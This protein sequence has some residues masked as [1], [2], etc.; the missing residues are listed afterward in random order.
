[1][2]PLDQPMPWGDIDWLIPKI[3][4]KKWTAVVCSSFEER[5]TGLSEWISNQNNSSSNHFLLRVQDPPSE[6]SEE[7]KL[8]TDQYE[9]V[10]T[11][12]LNKSQK[13]TLGLLDEPSVINEFFLD[14]TKTRTSILLDI[15]SMPK[16]IF[17]FLIKRLLD[18]SKVKDL[19]ICYTGANSYPEGAITQNAQSPSALP[20]FARENGS[21][22]G[23]TV[24]VSVGYM[25]FDLGD[26]LEQSEGRV[27]KF[28]FPFPPA[29]PAYRR[30]WR[31]LE[32]LAPLIPIQT[33]IQRINAMDMFAV[34][35][36]LVDLYEENG[37]PMDLIPLGPKPHSLAMALAH[38]QM[39]GNAE[40]IYPQPLA[41]NPQ[42]SLGVGRNVNGDPRIK[43]Y[44][45]RRNSI[46]FV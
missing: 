40:L 36:W 15:T 24:I 28:L 12:N 45:L 18:S 30:N 38:L 43:A 31:L 11:S 5:C 46:D 25:A 7:I 20:G 23:G 37:S 3:G 35:K 21:Q 1:M 10:I 27:L 13:K 19:V 33:E 22:S 16:R 44:C 42:Y 29:S 9:G 4:R 26:L 8:L 32:K 2:K 14:I 6:Y 34:Y 17:L 39:D 41:Y